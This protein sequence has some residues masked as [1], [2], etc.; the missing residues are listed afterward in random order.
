MMGMRHNDKNKNMAKNGR[1]IFRGQIRS[2][3]TCTIICTLVN[4]QADTIYVTHISAH[5]SYQVSL[6]AADFE[7]LILQ[8]F[9]TPCYYDFSVCVLTCFF[10]YFQVKASPLAHIPCRPFVMK[11][12]WWSVFAWVHTSLLK[13]YNLPI[14][15]HSKLGIDENK[16]IFRCH[17]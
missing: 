14:S 2:Q 1:A 6:Q 12:K 3:F 10:A 7:F 4:W 13:N 8:T 15:F 9:T 16:A 11:E 5:L 17:R